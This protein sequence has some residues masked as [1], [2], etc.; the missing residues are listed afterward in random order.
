M[1]TID[2]STMFSLSPA[3]E[4]DRAGDAS[5]ASVRVGMVLLAASLTIPHLGFTAREDLQQFAADWETFMRLGVCAAC[6]LYGL[7]HLPRTLG[8]FMRFPGAWTFL[9]SVWAIATLPL[10]IAPLYCTGACVLL[11][12]MVLFVPAV[13]LQLGGR[14]TILTVLVTLLLFALSNWVFYY[15]VPELGRSPVVI[16]GELKDSGFMYRLGGCPQTLGLQAAWAIGLILILG[17]ERCTRWST[18]LLPLGFALVTLLFT[19]SRTAVLACAAVVAVLCLRRVRLVPLL[20]A[21][22]AV[23]T[24]V[25]LILLIFGGELAGIDSED[26]ASRISRSGDAYEVYSLTGRTAIWAYA[27]EKIG[28]S[29]WVGWGYG[30]PRYLMNTHRLAA[31]TSFQTIHAHNIFLDIALSGGVIAA[32][33]LAAMFLS[34]LWGFVRNPDPVP[35]MVLVLALVASITEPILF[36]PMPRSHMVI[37]LIA[38]FWRQ[39]GASLDDRE[40]PLCSEKDR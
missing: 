5:L 28:E 19:Q 35:D 3:S 21:G 17:F 23:I 2:H 31:F 24:V 27:L 33:L 14:R 10:A 7:V 32:L 34:L 12:C 38:L 30:A 20:I 4:T 11:W 29:P 39:V 18:L 8:E 9:F 37:W 22:S 26:V 6:G 40:V 16:G 13:L 1:S 15:A 36:S 25:C